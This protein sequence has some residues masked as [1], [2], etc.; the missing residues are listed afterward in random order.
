MKRACLALLM[1]LGACAHYAPLPLS[2]APALL[3]NPDV[4]ALSQAAATIDRPYLRPTQIDL[5]VPLDGNAIAVI[6]VINNPDLKALR[7]RAGVSDAQVFAARL[8]PDPTFSIGASTVL[9]G[10]DPLPDLVST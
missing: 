6:A 4:A 5:A 2:S 9:S 8:L 3:A 7:E 1:P 10:P